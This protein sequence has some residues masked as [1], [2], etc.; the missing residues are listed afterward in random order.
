MKFL[1]RIKE[2]WTQHNITLSSEHNFLELERELDNIKR[3]FSG[4]SEVITLQRRRR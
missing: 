4:L 2:K 1:R 3:E